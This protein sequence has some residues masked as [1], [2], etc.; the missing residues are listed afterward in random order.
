MLERV[1]EEHAEFER[2]IARLQALRS[3]QAVC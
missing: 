1:D 3:V 2:C